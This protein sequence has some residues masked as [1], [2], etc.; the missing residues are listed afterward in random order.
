MHRHRMKFHAKE[1]DLLIPIKKTGKVNG[2]SK[3]ILNAERDI[4]NTFP[5]AAHIEK[6]TSKTDT[7]AV[8]NANRYVSSSR[9]KSPLIK[10]IETK[11]SP[12]FHDEHNN[13]KDGKPVRLI[14][15]QCVKSSEKKELIE[16][17]SPQTAVSWS[18]K[19]THPKG[20]WWQTESLLPFKPKSS[21]C[22]V[23]S[24]GSGK[25]YWTYRFLQNIKGMFDTDPPKTILYCYGV[26]QPLY[27]EMEEQLDV[28]LNEGLPNS[29]LIDEI[30]SNGSHNL[31]VIDDLIDQMVKSPNMELL[32]TQGCH[33]KNFTVVYL[34]QNLFQQGKNARTI[35]LNTWYLV[36]FRNLR[37][38]SQ[39]GHLEKQMYPGHSGILRE[40]YNDATTE[41]YGYLVIDSSPQ[42]DV[43]HRL[44]TKIFP[45]EDPVVYLPKV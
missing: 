20:P 33:H 6:S 34:T 18:P 11:G 17:L 10:Y 30:S 27:D 16:K 2:S 8:V 7:S 24:T 5:A 42:A 15:D 43:K 45:N 22:I 44:R 13:S 12:N 38:V 4:A 1:T 21:I 35:A 26:W 3:L 41:P 9:G 29:A 14:S 25:T 40:A 19:H 23:G 37:D 39:I 28:V 32:L 36:L 31:I